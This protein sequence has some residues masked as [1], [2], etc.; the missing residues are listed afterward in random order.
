MCCLFLLRGIKWTL[1]LCL[2]V[3]EVEVFFR[4]C[5]NKDNGCFEGW[6]RLRRVTKEEAG[7]YYF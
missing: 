6:R 2:S 3:Y 7:K 4:R 1:L 5:E